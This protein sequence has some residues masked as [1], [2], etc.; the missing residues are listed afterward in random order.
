MII[1]LQ[2]I[3]QDVWDEFI[4]LGYSHKYQPFQVHPHRHDWWQITW[5]LQKLS[6]QT[7]ST[8]ERYDFIVYSYFNTE[9]DT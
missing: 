6:E 9:T 5:S 4:C 8:K 3:T 1:T 2:N 7:S